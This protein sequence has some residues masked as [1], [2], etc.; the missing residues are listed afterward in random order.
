MN[1]RSRSNAFTLIELLV[2]I[3]I[4]ALLIAMLMPALGQARLSGE[5]AVC[6]SASKQIALGMSMY[7]EDYE[8]RFHL[9]PNYG[10]WDN[11]ANGQPWTLEEINRMISGVSSGAHA[12]WA[13][14]YKEYINNHRQIFRCPSA[15][16][17]DL[18]TGYT[19][20]VNQQ[21]CTYGLNGFLTVTDSKASPKLEATFPDASKT[22]IMHDAWEHLL[23]ANG[24]MLSSFDQPRNITQYRDRS[25]GEQAVFEYYRHLDSSQVLWLDGHVSLIKKS[26]GRDIPSTWYN[27]KPPVRPVS[28]SRRTGR[29]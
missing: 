5:T 7:R 11:P 16:L 27:G 9:A 20:W 28:G 10:L 2:V 6:G 1:P 22:I 8:D 21:E 19:D 4:I 23:E 18:D 26:D 13:V 17:M 25:Y 12:Y 15:Q 14:A 24:D 3:S 29:N